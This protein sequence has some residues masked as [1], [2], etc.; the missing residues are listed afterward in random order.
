MKIIIDGE[1]CTANQYIDAERTHWRKGAAIKKRESARAQYAASGLDPLP[2]GRY[3][4]TF[5]WY[6]RN[7]KTDPGNIAFAEKFVSDGLQ[8]AGVL[9]NDNWAWVNSFH[10]L[11]RIDLNDPRV[12]VEIVAA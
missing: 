10:H 9:G 12:E 7:N 1:F 5:V 8:E 4:I 6:R 3:D 11:F 2:P